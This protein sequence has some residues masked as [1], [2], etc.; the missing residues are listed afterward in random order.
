MGNDFLKNVWPD[1]EVVRPISSGSYGTVYEVVR[2]DH[3]VETHDAV[4][5]ISI[6]QDD[7]ELSSL[8]SAGVSDT[9]D[10]KRAY[11]LEAVDEITNEIRLMEEFRGSSNI[12]SINDFKVLERTDRFGWDVYIRMELLKP[13]VTYLSDKQLNEELA[14]RV[15][16][17]LCSALE[18]CSKRSVIHR[19][20]KPDNILVNEFGDFKL[21]DF[22]IARI[23]ENQTGGLSRK[24][25]PN[26]MAPEVFRGERYDATA[27]F[28]SLGLVLYWLLN[29]RR[30]P[31]LNPDKQLLGPNEVQDALR[32]RLSGEALPP[33]K[34]ASPEMTRL[35]LKA[36][37]PSPARRFATAGE[38]KEALEEVERGGSLA[39]GGRGGSVGQDGSGRDGGGGP[40]KVSR[41][42]RPGG[43]VAQGGR[44]QDGGGRRNQAD[45]DPGRSKILED[46]TESA[47]NPF[48][49]FLAVMLGG[50]L[51]IL[52]AGAG[53]IFL[54]REGG[55]SADRE[56]RVVADAAED[57]GGAGT[58]AAA[59][60]DADATDPAGGEPAE[61]GTSEDQPAGEQPSEDLSA[62]DK[63][64]AAEGQEA[65][66]TAANYK[67]P[68]SEPSQYFYHN[69]HTYGF[70]NASAMGFTDYDGVSAFCHE[71]GGHL[72]VIN[73]SDENRYLFNILKENYSDTAF[74][75]YT[76]KEEEGVWVWDGDNPDGY[77]NWSNMG[78]WHLPDNGKGWGGDEDY[79]EFN[80]D[81]EKPDEVPNDSTWNDAA[82]MENTSWF[83]CEW[84]YEI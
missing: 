24:G 40:D 55:G 26:Y 31:F 82:F 80:Y 22:G 30:L 50:V 9:D 67:R 79:A 52:I 16:K 61:E 68:E 72:A 21:T 45:D 56:D 5:V 73:D 48:L 75:G 41:D 59:A 53:V 25:T 42:D 76:D 14:I 47:T 65:S 69:G 32:R 33:P 27:D 57:T 38:M 62:D 6:P 12:V 64:P 20:I 81:A 66:E 23:L 29:K 7:S 13:L 54:R 74:F 39:G 37:D 11:Y 2:S 70:Y 46:H 83:I 1:W 77:T 36:C 78:D 8:R 15:G 17:D 44:G 49:K 4:K 84:E 19:D 51:V 58:E 60:D 35:I 3:G 28:Y 34:Y 71:Q 43:G 18:R 10:A 63:T